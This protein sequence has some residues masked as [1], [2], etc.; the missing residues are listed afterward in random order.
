VKPDVFVLGK[1]LGGGIIPISAVVASAALME[2]LKP[3]E[4]G[5]TFGG[6]PLACAVS[7]EAM[8]V[9]VE[10]HL[11]A[12]TAELGDYLLTRLRGVKSKWVKEV[13]GRGL[14]VGI[15]LFP[16][17]GG[18]R[19]FCER[20]LHEGLL[21]KETHEHVIRLAPPLTILREELDW[22]IDR[23]AKVLMEG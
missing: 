5:S 20:L 7:R 21:C 1:A 2:V 8:R 13:R 6:Y 16:K 17:A 22:A 14:F 3:G 9:L 12:R 10:E 11:P 18:A 23:V 15:E 4:H 19:S